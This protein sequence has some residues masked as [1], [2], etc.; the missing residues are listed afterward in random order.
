[1]DISKYVITG[2]I[3]AATALYAGIIL[4][5]EGE[6]KELNKKKED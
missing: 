3:T 4:Y 6:Q 5:Q 1:M 2:V